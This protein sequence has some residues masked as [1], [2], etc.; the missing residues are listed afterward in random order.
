[1]FS[2]ENYPNKTVY[3]ML[4][5]IKLIILYLYRV[6]TALKILNAVLFGSSKFGGPRKN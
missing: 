2:K 3:L 1:M 5:Y 6:K 4:L